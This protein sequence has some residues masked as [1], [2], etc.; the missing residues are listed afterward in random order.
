M[1]DMDARR[2]DLAGVCHIMVTPFTADED[3][4]EA[5]LR[6]V[7]DFAIGAGV[8]GLVALGIM[9]EAHKLSDS[10]RRRVLDVVVDQAAGRV[11]VVAGCSAEATRV[12]VERAREAERAGAAAAMVAPPRNLKAPTLLRRHFH[13]VADAAGLPV[14]VQDEPVT[15]GVELPAELLAEILAHP[16]VRYVK[17]EESPSPMKVTRILNAA[18]DAKCF[19]GLG[20]LYLFEELQRGAVGV[21]TGFGAPEVLVRIHELHR[22]GDVEG[23]RSVFYRYLPLIRFEAQLGVGGVAIRK[24]VLAQRGVIATPVVRRPAGGVDDRTLKELMELLTIL[25]LDG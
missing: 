14:V 1:S 7:V 15:T 16:R 17:V 11:P 21:M 12:A 5:S 10:E 20:G 23:A 24:H 8:G 3:L 18:P 4:D 13:D 9:G 22:R 19:G 25:E 6:R 2:S